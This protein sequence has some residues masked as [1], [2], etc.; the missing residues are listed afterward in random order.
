MPEGDTIYR[1]ARALGH[2]LEGNVVTR[3]ET[4]LAPLVSVDDNTPVAGRTVEKVESRGKW[5]L[6]HFSG[7]LILVTH[8]MGFG[9]EIGDYAAFLAEGGII[10]SGPARE[11]FGTPKNSA[12]REFLAK[13]L[14]Y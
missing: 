10:E 4:A 7:D 2:V 5:L 12:T 8:E 3:F 9:K 1:A 14:Q 13:V 11:V 6:I